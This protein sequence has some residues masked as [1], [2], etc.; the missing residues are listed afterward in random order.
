MSGRWEDDDPAQM[1]ENVR[2]LVAEVHAL[3]AGADGK[4]RTIENLRTLLE[5]REAE[6]TRL[7]QE[8]ERIRALAEDPGSDA[9]RE[10]C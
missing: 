3:R 8:I 6:N 2:R 10:A 4:D 5:Q 1:R 7:Q 9:P